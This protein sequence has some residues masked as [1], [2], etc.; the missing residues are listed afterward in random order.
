MFIP[1]PLFR[2][3]Y[4]SGARFFPV[5]ALVRHG[6]LVPYAISSPFYP[7]SLMLARARAELAA[8]CSQLCVPRDTFVWCPEQF[9][10][11][12][13]PLLSLRLASP[14]LKSCKA[15][16]GRALTRPLQIDDHGSSRFLLVQAVRD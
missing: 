13:S 12:H 14:I 11:S 16:R 9:Y 5:S 2:L 10:L 4:I 3:G 6:G 8:R 7:S 15:Q 1:G